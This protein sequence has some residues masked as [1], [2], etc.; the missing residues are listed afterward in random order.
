M[1][2]LTL[3]VAAITANLYASWAV[4]LVG[5][6]VR[7][8]VLMAI[9]ALIFGTGRAM[10]GTWAGGVMAL[11]LALTIGALFPIIVRLLF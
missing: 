3:L 2:T 9:A 6:I 10:T 7:F 4:K 11:Y 1:R 5:F 8:V